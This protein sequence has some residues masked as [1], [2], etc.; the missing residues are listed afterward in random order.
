MNVWSH[1]I[2]AVDEPMSDELTKTATKLSPRPC[3]EATDR[4]LISDMMLGLLAFARYICSLP[5]SSSFVLIDN[6]IST[7]TIESTSPFGDS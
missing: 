7:T 4:S 1:L 2:F 5:Q 3:I 6:Y